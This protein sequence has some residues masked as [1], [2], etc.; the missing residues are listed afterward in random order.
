MIT[1]IT[2]GMTPEEY[3]ASIN[4]NLSGVL[5][6]AYVPVTSSM[7]SI[8]LQATI[9]TNLSKSLSIVGVKGSTMK[10]TLDSVFNGYGYSGDTPTSLAVTSVEDFTRISFTD[11]SGGL[12]KHEILESFQ[13]GEYSLLTTLNEGVESYDYE[14]YQN[15]DYKFRVRSK[16]GSVYS[17]FTDVNQHDTPLV[18]KTDQSTLNQIA[19]KTF[20]VAAGGTINVDW[21]DGSDNDFTE[22]TTSDFTK[23]YIT[24]GIYFIKISGDIDKWTG[25]DWV[26]QSDL[27]GELTKWI[28]PANLTFFH[29]YGNS[30]ISGDITNWILPEGC[31]IFHIGGNDFYGD[32]TDWIIPDTT[33]DLRLGSNRLT[34]DLSDWTFPDNGKPIFYF[35]CENN[36]LTGDL[37]GWTL[38]DNMT[39]LSLFH[40][41]FEGDLTDWVIPS[42]LSRLVLTGDDVGESNA[43]TGNISEWDCPSI[44]SDTLV[45]IISCPNIPFSGDLSL[46]SM[47]AGTRSFA[48]NFKNANLTKLPRGC[49]KWVS[50]YNFEANN[51][52]TQ[53]IDDILAYIDAYFADGVAPL[54]SCAYTLNGTGM[55]IPSAAGLASKSSIEGKYTTAGFTATILVNS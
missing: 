34:G 22:G 37:S 5:L 48:V 46:W 53:E 28:F 21:G 7:T 44:E 10:S 32:I 50:E 24:E 31:G 49:F 29:F 9:N 14:S 2:A 47:Y 23:D 20:V 40:N 35:T 51:C 12:A 1:L 4:T 36:L 6:E 15:A 17:T 55:G 11:E 27:F 26:E 3:I 42:T 30:N 33:Y 16:L 38:P 43:F 54:I 13:G 25:L 39:Q 45:N 18:M 19:I 41:N 52:A 8:E